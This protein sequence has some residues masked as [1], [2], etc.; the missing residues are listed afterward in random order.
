MTRKK[1]RGSGSVRP[2]ADFEFA[3]HCIAQDVPIPDNSGR[4]N[5]ARDAAT[6]N[7]YCGRVAAAGH[8]IR[9]V[10]SIF[11]EGR[12][13]DPESRKDLWALEHVEG[14][15]QPTDGLGGVW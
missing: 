14:S 5:Q 3:L 1:R 6:I 15:L 10:R 2:D 8:A 11:E 12:S 4:G 9:S 7:W 13:S